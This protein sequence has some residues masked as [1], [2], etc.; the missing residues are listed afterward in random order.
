[1]APN[2]ERWRPLARSEWSPVV[3]S[4]TTMAVPRIHARATYGTCTNKG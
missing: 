1:V 2:R 3:T 4:A